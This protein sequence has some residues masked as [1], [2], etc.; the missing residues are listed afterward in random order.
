MICQLC[1]KEK[2]LVRSHLVA[3]CLLE[4]LKAGGHVSRYHGKLGVLPARTPTGE[5]DTEILCADCD[6]Y[7]S[8]WE[9]YSSRF[10]HKEAPRIEPNARRDFYAIQQYDY[11]SLKLCFLSI[12]WRM[13][14]SRRSIYVDIDLGPYEQLIR[15]MLLD[16]NPGLATEFPILLER[17][18]NS[19][20]AATMWG[21]VRIKHEGFN[22]FRL[23]LPGY[24]INI[25]VDKKPLR[26]DIQSSCIS[27]NEPLKVIFC[28]MD[29]GKQNELLRSVF[30]NESATKA[31]FRR[32]RQR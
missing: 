21:P 25:K 31:L 9:N 24:R 23:G 10:L 17:Y 20:G 6:S 1:D 12:L 14:V 26:P 16:K 30:A 3:R 32:K 7:F 28:R 19:I 5:Y 11:A 22:M 8:P 27:P 18:K 15:Q 2:P 4:P 13:S 29:Q